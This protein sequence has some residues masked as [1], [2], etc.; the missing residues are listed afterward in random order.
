MTE[1]AISIRGLTKYY[2]Q[3][4]A[5]ANI[6]FEIKAGEFFGLLGPNGAGKTTTINV[7]TGLANYQH[8]QVA[9]FG[10][11]V[12]REY[13]QSRALIGLVPQ[14]FNFDS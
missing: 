5:I 4:K 6:T 14:E 11:D 12:T 2:R 13:R 3:F 10:H 9:I 7:I 8:G 1:A